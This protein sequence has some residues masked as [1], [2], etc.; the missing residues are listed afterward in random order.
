MKRPLEGV[1]V[2]DCG[3]YHA[4]P[5][6]PAILGDL[7][8]EVIKIEEPGVGDP[9]RAGKRIGSVPLE[10]PGDRS[11]FNEGAN[12]NK[13]SV[14]LN[15][16]SEKGQEILYRLVD[17][18]DVF[19]TSMR[20]GAI[21]RL[22]ITYPTIRKINPQIIYATVSAFG[23]KG[24]D[25]HRGGFDYQG[26]ARSGFMWSMGEE[27]GPPTVNQFAIIDQA[28][29]IMVSHQIITALYMRERTGIAQEVHV[30]ILGTSMFLLYFNVLMAQAIGY[31]M[32]RHQRN[33]D[34]AMRNF[35]ECSDGRWLMMT[36][37]PPDRFWRPLCQALGHPEL[38]NDP[39]FEDDE[40]RLEN[41]EQLVAI[42]DEIFATRTAAEWLDTFS[43]YDLFVCAVNSLTDLGNDPQV[44]ANDYIVDFE[45][46]TLGEIKI[47]GYPGHFSETWAG[48]TRAAPD[49]GEHTDEVL[50]NICGYSKKKIKGLRE[51]GVI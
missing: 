31:E 38:E 35:Y 13:K 36:L 1:R 30:S 4:G 8:A 43:D 15:L 47:P 25:S 41:A 40:K 27:G 48:T 33:K 37:T 28:T 12:R 49:L 32:P 24:P 21:E 46:P 17:G 42:F 10:I 50:M 34:H 16:Q 19:L 29:A 20:R 18:A 5:G 7:G 6:G 44:I 45:H 2:L 3:I 9:I 22:N 14:T 23:P 39:R 11:F 26:Q 51:E